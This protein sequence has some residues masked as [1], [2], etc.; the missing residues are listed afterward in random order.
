MFS[1]CLKQIGAING[2]EEFKLGVTMNAEMRGM[3]FGLKTKYTE[4][5]IKT[6]QPSLNHLKLTSKRLYFKTNFNNL[7]TRLAFSS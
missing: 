6:D 4:K 3:L 1:Y 2:S 5:F 7:Y